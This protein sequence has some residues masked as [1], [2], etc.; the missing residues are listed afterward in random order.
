MYMHWAILHYVHST[1]QL[2]NL[3]LVLFLPFFFFVHLKSSHL[4]SGTEYSSR[5]QLNITETTAHRLSNVKCVSIVQASMRIRNP[6]EIRQTAKYGSPDIRKRPPRTPTMSHLKYVPKHKMPNMYTHDDCI[7]LFGSTSNRTQRQSTSIQK[8]KKK[9]TVRL[10]SSQ[11][12]IFILMS[13]FAVW[14]IGI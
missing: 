3:R 10:P 9:L 5:N 12:I 8:R 4:L 14:Y 6:E 13:L 2:A 11:I 1:P 7:F